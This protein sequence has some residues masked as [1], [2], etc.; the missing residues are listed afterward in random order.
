M[1]HPHTEQPAP[2]RKGPCPPALQTAELSQCHCALTPELVTK[3]FLTDCRHGSARSKG[4]DVASLSA[5]R[6][7]AAFSSLNPLHTGPK[8]IYKGTAK[9]SLY[10]SLS[11]QYKDFNK[12]TLPLGVCHRVQLDYLD[13]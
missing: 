3:L 12:K 11:L 2:G 13:K 7:L 8:T 6:M 1:K 4:K 10:A 9:T 5:F